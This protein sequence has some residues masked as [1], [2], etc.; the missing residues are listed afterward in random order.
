MYKI[1]YN[2]ATT[3]VNL[4]LPH[5]AKTDNLTLILNFVFGIL[6][7]ISFLIITIAGVQ[8]VASS[9]DPQKVAKARA[10]ILYALVGLTVAIFAA[11][12]VNFV[13]G[14]TAS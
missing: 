14:K 6:G 5:N 8:F 13:I 7:A 11:V 4:D 1:I 12:I 9:G 10:T 2:F 3:L